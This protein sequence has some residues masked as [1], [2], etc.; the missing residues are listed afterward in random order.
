[1]KDAP[2]LA[3]TFRSEQ[4]LR[5]YGITGGATYVRRR[6]DARM[7]R[8]PPGND[9]EWIRHVQTWKDRVVV[10]ENLPTDVCNRCGE[11]YFPVPWLIA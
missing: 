11:F 6:D 3:V 1:M 8:L 9:V 2:E 7:S 10:F 4:S 5:H